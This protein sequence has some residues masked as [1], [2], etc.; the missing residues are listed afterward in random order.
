MGVEKIT[1]IKADMRNE[2]NRL[3]GPQL[4]IKLPSKMSIEVC[5]VVDSKLVDELDEDYRFTSKLYGDVSKCYED[6]VKAI[7]QH[8]KYT[9]GVAEMQQRPVLPDDIKDMK[10]D[11]E[12]SW[13]EQADAARKIGKKHFD[14]WKKI[15]DDRKKYRTEVTA[16]LA[17]GS[18]GLAF[19]GAAAIPTLLAGGAP[20]A[21]AIYSIAKNLASIAQELRKVGKSLDDLATKIDAD[22]DKLK[23]EAQKSHKLAVAKETL[24]VFLRDFAKIHNASVVQVRKD[25]TAYKGKLGDLEIKCQG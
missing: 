24:N 2:V 22:I 20:G 25:L 8:V 18:I 15:K 7:A 4:Q 13:K 10:K 12:T 5:L 3:V 1:L 23:G 9:V 6:L 14:K 16:T 17:F 11:I 19:A 21:L